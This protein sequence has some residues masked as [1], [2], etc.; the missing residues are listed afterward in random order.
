M[1][2]PN[3]PG[4]DDPWGQPGG[5]DP[6]K[7]P[8]PYG[9]PPYG[10]PPYGQPPYG[11]PPY[12]YQPPYGQPPYGYQPPYG[13]PPYGY[14][15]YGQP[16]YGYQPYGYQPYGYQPY[17]YPA[18]AYGYGYRPSP[19][20]GG[21]PLASMG[22]RFWG[23][24]L[25]GLILGVPTVIIAIVTGAFRW[26]TTEN[27]DLDGTCTNQVHFGSPWAT[28][29]IALLLGLAYAAYFV[30]VRTQTI[31]H[32]AVG[33]RVI[34]ADTGQP[35][36]AGRGALRWLVLSLTGAVCTLGYWSPFFDSIRRQGW[37]DKAAGSIAVSAQR[38][39]G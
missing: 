23:L 37:H 4:P 34:D 27:C 20:P 2:S 22:R 24:V 21:V 33:I 29:L 38:H 28:N 25:D 35:I 6:S 18:A 30:G 9:Q 12:G 31:G 15:P 7:A 32:M 11:Q 39:P 10:Q 17:G 3:P 5:F 8:P 26:T 16:P 14:Q 36:G 13:Q 1:T 19:A